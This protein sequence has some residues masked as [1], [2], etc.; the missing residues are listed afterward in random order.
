MRANSEATNEVVFSE[1]LSISLM[2]HLGRIEARGSVAD[3]VEAV[4]IEQNR[5]LSLVAAEDTKSNPC[6]TRKLD[7]GFQRFSALGSS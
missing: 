6:W 3:L 4:V 7:S 2:T 5:K 1:R